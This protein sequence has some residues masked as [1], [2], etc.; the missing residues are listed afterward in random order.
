MVTTHEHAAPRIR[1]STILL[2]KGG[3]R[4]NFSF[5]KDGNVAG[6]AGGPGIPICTAY[7]RIR[8]YKAN[9][10]LC[11]GF[12]SRQRHAPNEGLTRSEDLAGLVGF[13][14]TET[15]IDAIF[16]RRNSSNL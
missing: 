3:I 7:P 2:S 9:D 15:G 6:C 10:S 12:R 14:L 1:G 16:R 5:S 8:D 4:S 13:P 11:Q